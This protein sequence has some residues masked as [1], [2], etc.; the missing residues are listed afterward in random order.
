LKIA[1]SQFHMSGDVSANARIMSDH[2]VLASQADAVV[3]HFPETALSGY[4]GAHHR[5]LEDFDWFNL[6]AHQRELCRMARSLGIWVVFGSTRMITD[7][8][9]RN[10]V[11]VISSDGEI[12]GIYDKRRLYKDEV[13][14]YGQGHKP[15]TVDI[16]GIKCGF[17]ICYDS[18]FP[19]LYT[20]YRDQGVSLLFH[21]YYNANSG[22]GP[23][24]LD[25]LMLAQLRTRAADNLMWISASNSSEPHSR[26]GSC[27]VRPDGS[28]IESDRHK[29]GIV[30]DDT[31]ISDLGWT[32]DNLIS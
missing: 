1:T 11:Q 12:V 27:I 15:L 3:I 20:Q 29:P 28:A 9:P 17:L 2:M 4:I 32:Y 24:S 18:S 19:E 13:F 10:C 7:E 16:S 14:H 5:N 31:S 8:K 26:L 21:S 22:R 30:V 25:D 23:D 6:A